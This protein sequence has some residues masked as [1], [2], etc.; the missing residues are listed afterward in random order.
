LLLISEKSAFN[1][2]HC[3]IIVRICPN[4][5]LNAEDQQN[6]T[7]RSDSNNQALAGVNILKKEQLTERFPM[8]T[9]ISFNV[10][11]A[12]SVLV[13]SFIGYSSQEVVVGTQTAINV[14]L[15]ESAV[16]LMK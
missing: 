15:T 16:G 10:A 5:C 14:T 9:E 1:G 6:V 12:N 4:L 3:F 8:W 7:G 11:S 13:F 2:T